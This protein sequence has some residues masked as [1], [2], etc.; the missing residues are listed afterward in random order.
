MKGKGMSK[1]AASSIKCQEENCTVEN[2]T[3]KAFLKAYRR[4]EK[5][6]IAEMLMRLEFTSTHKLFPVWDHKYNSIK[7]KIH[8]S[9]THAAKKESGQVKKKR[10]ST[11]EK[12]LMGK[13]YLQRP[14]SLA[15]F[16]TFILTL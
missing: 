8:K 7:N 16:P 1:K 6:T 13:D 15:F 5:E 12:I 9:I 10:K 2:C 3:V 14:H 11:A 4:E